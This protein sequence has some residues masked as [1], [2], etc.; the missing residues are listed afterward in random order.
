MG[1]E[2]NKQTVARFDRLTAAGEVDA[3]DDLCTPDMTNHALAETRSAGLEG[4][5]QFLRECRQDPGKGAWIRTM[6]ADQSVVTIAE[7]DYVVQFGRRTGAWPGGHFRGAE[8]PAGEYV[9]DVAFMYRF[10]DGRI[11]ERWA[12]RDDLAM[13]QQLGGRLAPNHSALGTLATP[14]LSRPGRSTVTPGA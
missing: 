12:V 5:K 14:D 1:F 2:E 4:T 3:L 10:H 6:M 9:Y 13:I 7:A 11:A 8:V